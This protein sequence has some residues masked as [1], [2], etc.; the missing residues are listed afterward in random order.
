MPRRRIALVGLGGAAVV[1]ALPG[2]ARAAGIGRVQATVGTLRAVRGTGLVDLA[3][4]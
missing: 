3:V 1:A 2:S 4:G